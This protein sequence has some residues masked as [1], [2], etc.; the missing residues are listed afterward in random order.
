MTSQESA[1]PGG[2][3]GTAA[4]V[5]ADI[6]AAPTPYHA[7]ERAGSL[8][9]KAGFTAVSRSEP[10]PTVAGRYLTSE[11][12][13][14]VAWVQPDRPAEG[15]VVVGTHTDSPNLRVTS[16]PDVAV[17]GYDQVG[18]EIYGGALF[19]SWLDRD[20]GL[21][22]R[23]AIRTPSG[24]EQRLMR[25]DRP[26]LRI[27]QLAIHLQPDLA[28]EGGQRPSL[29]P[30]EHLTPIWG[31]S[32]APAAGVRRHVA[33]LLDVDEADV[34]AWDLMTYDTQPPAIVGR[35]NDLIASARLDNQGCTFAAVDALARLAEDAG[36][37]TPVL[38]LF[39]HEEV[40]SA[41]PTGAVGTA[42]GSILERISH[43]TGVD[44]PDHLGALAG[45]TVISADAGHATH[46]NHLDRHDKHH[47]VR[48]NGGVVVKRNARLRYAT[49]S[50]SEG[51]LQA[52]AEAAGVPLQQY[53]HRND[54][55][56]GS[57]I[58]PLTAAGLSAST[59]DIGIPV[60]A[61]HSI[62]ETAGVRDVEQLSALL[63]AAWSGAAAEH[64]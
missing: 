19:N 42:L 34:L 2:L 56:C 31:L 62:R 9:H 55:P 51:F 28:H 49:D 17:A 22:G 60:L 48:L 6:E 36:R 46:P 14:L 44:R 8:L 32:G 63:H 61:M 15:F 53:S 47:P 23:V 58:G 43:A 33:D 57:T 1:G 12:G 39:D 18:I 54:M 20:L 27:P 10:F 3:D 25:G 13:F 59:V 11:G 52:V 64:T 50:I 30:Q 45:S 29:N 24:V 7:V 5:V 26:V 21:A 38:C 37:R 4:R 40:G 35:D 16:R 41:S